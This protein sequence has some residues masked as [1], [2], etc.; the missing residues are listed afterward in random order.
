MITWSNTIESIPHEDAAVVWGKEVIV[1]RDDYL[2]LSQQFW[3][4]D[5][6]LVKQMD[7]TE[8]KFMD[9][10]QYRR[11]HAHVQTRIPCRMDRDVGAGNRF[12]YRDNG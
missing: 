12:R 4:Q 2:M 3:D 9:D 1:I 10:A 11:S 7:T 6:L 5:N 8:I